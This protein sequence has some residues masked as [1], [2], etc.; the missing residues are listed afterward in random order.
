M[1][2]LFACSLRTSHTPP[3]RPS[4]RPVVQRSGEHA[5]KRTCSLAIWRFSVSAMLRTGVPAQLAFQGI[6]GFSEMARVAN[7]RSWRDCGTANR[8]NGEIP[9]MISFDHGLQKVKSKIGS[10]ETARH[11]V[12]VP[13]TVAGT[14]RLDLA[15]CQYLHR[16][17]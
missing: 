8:G 10:I 16:H 7:R 13:D 17:G 3:R 6:W 12:R 14:C 2:I 15:T 5:V 9:A 4:T 11:G 1:Q